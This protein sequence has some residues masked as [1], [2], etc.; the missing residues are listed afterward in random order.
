MTVKVGRQ[1]LVADNAMLDLFCLWIAIPYACCLLHA[2]FN[3]GA[4]VS[5]CVPGNPCPCAVGTATMSSMEAASRKGGKLI[6]VIQVRGGGSV[7]GVKV[8]E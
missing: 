7:K 1:C 6:E 4:L 3:R 5:V 8:S 2:A